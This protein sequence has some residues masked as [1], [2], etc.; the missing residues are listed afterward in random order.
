MAQFVES[1]VTISVGSKFKSTSIFLV[2]GPSS[3]TADP[4]GTAAPFFLTLTSQQVAGWQ[5]FSGPHSKAQSLSAF[6]T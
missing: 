1:V 3:F 4:F 2:P 6:L 5:S